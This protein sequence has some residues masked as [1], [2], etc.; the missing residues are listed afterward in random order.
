MREIPLLA[1]CRPM[2]GDRRRSPMTASEQRNS[3]TFPKRALVPVHIRRINSSG[4][5]DA[6]SLTRSFAV[7]MGKFLVGKH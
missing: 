1:A 4:H 3:Q 5:D 2:D 7:S 6:G